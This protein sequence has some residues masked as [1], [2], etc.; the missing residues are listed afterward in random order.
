MAITDSKRRELCS[1]MAFRQ[2]FDSVEPEQCVGLLM[3]TLAV[4]RKNV[5]DA[6]AWWQEAQA[7]FE[8]AKDALQNVSR[9]YAIDRLGE[10][11]RAILMAAAEEI[12]REPSHGKRVINDAIRLAR[13]YAT[14]EAGALVNALLDG[15]CQRLQGANVDETSIATT[16]QAL[17]QAEADAHH[18]LHT[19][20]QGSGSAS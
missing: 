7:G 19:H 8:V 15:L 14:P 10:V 17:E 5:Y 4:T 16:A 13:K 6:I 11:E 1:L 3:E 2:Q 18:I 12:M 20:N 9:S